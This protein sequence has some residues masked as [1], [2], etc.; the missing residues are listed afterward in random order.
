MDAGKSVKRPIYS[1]YLKI[2]TYFMAIS[3][4]CIFILGM[5][6][7]AFFFYKINKT[8][9]EYNKLL[10][11]N[12]KIEVQKTLE[13]VSST[14]YQLGTNRLVNKYLNESNQIDYIEIGNIQ[15]TINDLVASNDHF[16]SI[17]V[18]YE[19]RNMIITSH[20]VYKF[21]TFVDRNWI[22]QSKQNDDIFTWIGKHSIIKDSL[23]QTKYEVISLVGKMPFYKRYTSG[24]IV[25]NI[26]EKFIIDKLHAVSS[27]GFGELII[28]DSNG[29]L[30]SSTQHSLP[31]NFQNEYASSIKYSKE[32]NKGVI[33][34]SDSKWFLLN[35]AYSEFNQWNYI[36]HTP[37]NR[38]LHDF[39]IST[40]IVFLSI[41]IVAGV[42]FV[43]ASRFSKKVYSP[44]INLLSFVNGAN[45]NDLRQDV[46][47]LEFK[48]IDTNVKKIL[49]EKNVL[50]QQVQ[51]MLPSLKEKFFAGLFWGQILKAKYIEEY[52]QLLHIDTSKYVKYVVATLRLNEYESLV[53][54]Y[55]GE[56]RILF[57]E[58]V[59]QY[60]ESL[61]ET[62]DLFCCCVSNNL[63]RV[64]F[65]VGFKSSNAPEIDIVNICD[66]ILKYIRNNFPF[67]A[68]IGVGCAVTQFQSLYISCNQSMDVLDQ[69]LLYE[70]NQV[71][72]YNN[73]DSRSIG[74]Y[75]NPLLYE[76]TLINAIKTSNEEE[77]IRVL[78]EIEDLIFSKHYDISLIRQFYISIINIIFV[79]R[80]EISDN[81]EQVSN[82]LNHLVSE[83][84]KEHSLSGIQEITKTVCINISKVIDTHRFDKAN[85]TVNDVIDFLKEN[86]YKDISLDDVSDKVAYTPTYINK[87]LKSVL[88]KTFYDIL[89][90][91]R[92][93]KAKEFLSNSDLQIN[94]IADS[95]GY[96]NVQS[97]IRMFKKTVGVTPGKY[98]EMNCNANEK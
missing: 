92:I 95:V 91:I 5:I 72:L 55:S 89:T 26:K 18:V 32:N 73:I 14:V 76:K 50:Q 87:I 40:G 19:D 15:S 51:S 23:I 39:A 30:V 85:K 45:T 79:F 12:V 78:E 49:K 53:A 29:S 71:I 96:V 41:V 34:K 74:T 59:R 77:I 48:Q 4:C 93:D 16:D 97:F 83:I 20:G 66:D 2:M 64:S 17:Y 58:L 88:Q 69:S 94:Q 3:I 21:D 10:L 31:A 81:Q 27:Q 9:S 57:I 28:T 8:T 37:I 61:C 38:L 24:Y 65:I 54:S 56:E 33:V 6:L 98:R 60:I 43:I 67:T 42:A 22:N 36:V 86:Y 80:L 35:V 84:Y 63:K 25:I 47:Y 52:V 11:Q 7:S 70:H 82:E 44:V 75:I 90:D 46:E 13:H 1:Y 62:K 68:T